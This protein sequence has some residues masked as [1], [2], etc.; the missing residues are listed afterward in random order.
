VAYVF[1]PVTSRRLGLSL[2]VDLTPRKTCTYDCLY[3]QVGR[4]TQIT[5]EPNPFVPVEEVIHE[6]ERKLRHVTPDFVTVS[7]S[8]EPTLH[9]QIDEIIA[10]IK[11]RRDFRVAVLTNGSL[12]WRR[13]VM[14]RVLGADMI[15]PTFST[16]FEE[17]YRAIHR[18]HPSLTLDLL[19]RGL[20]NLR[21][22]LRGRL[23]L[24]VMLLKGFNDSEREI[25]ALKSVIEE[26]GPDRVQ[27]NTVV[28]PPSDSRALAL[29][30]ET[31]ED[32]KKIVGSMGETI[33]DRQRKPK[34]QRSDALFAQVLEMAK[35]RP[36]RAMDVANAL[37]APLGQVKNLLRILEERGSL[38]SREHGSETFYIA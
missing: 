16:A 23:F 35:R 14:E 2:G 11:R 26:I 20:K 17:T 31:L 27:L 13:E 1:G 7:G 32:I 18:P 15:M 30:R 12:L 10:Y 37:N 38:R 25:V 19:I 36:V 6:L 3:C 9:S 29:D 28:R 5:A 4:T 34:D 8:G 22:S 21:Q 24:E 33:A